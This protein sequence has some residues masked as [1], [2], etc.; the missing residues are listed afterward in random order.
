MEMNRAKEREIFL[1]YL[2]DVYLQNP[3]LPFSTDIVYNELSRFNVING[4]H[5]IID[6]ESLLVVQLNLN[7]KFRTNKSV[8]TFGNGYFWVIENRNNKKDSDFYNDLFNSVKLY[9]SVDAENI[10]KVSEALFKFM[11]DENIVMQSKIAKGMRNDALV[12]RVATAEDAKKVSNFLKNLN[13]QSKFKPNPFLLESGNVSVAMDGRL[14]YNSTLSKLIKEYLVSNKNSNS[15]DCVSCDDFTDFIK[16][17]IEL[18]RGNTKRSF[19]D[20]YQIKSEDKYLDFI[21]ISNFICKNMENTLTVDDIF[22]YQEIKLIEANAGNKM[23][24]KE[25][26]DK[27]L[28]VVNSLANYYSVDDVHKI[29]MNFITNA[30]VKVFTRRDDIRTVISDNFSPQDVKNIISNLGWNAFLSAAMGT[31]DK[32]GEEWLYY[33]IDNYFKG[34]GILG[35]TREGGVRSGLGLVIPPQLLRDVIVN[36]LEEKSMDISSISLTQLILEEIEKLDEKKVNG[37]K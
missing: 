22:K 24:S 35:F 27:I 31:Y 3:N 7:N 4:E 17:Q 5:Y 30:D 26:E 8:N 29:I 18:L 6:N 33:A 37:R 23:Y 21:M 20:L 16:N 25:D 32:Y 1:K 2:S 28:Y 9:V 10:Y 19:M 34:K 12:C 11:I 14:S 36:K 15:L 13:Y